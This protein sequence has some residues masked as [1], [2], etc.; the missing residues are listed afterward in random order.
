M[1]AVLKSTPPGRHSEQRDD[2][3]PVRPH[4]A[5]SGHARTGALQGPLCR[6]TTEGKHQTPTSPAQRTASTRVGGR[7]RLAA[8]VLAAAALAVISPVS[9]LARAHADTV[10][11]LVNVTVRPGYNFPNADAALA[12][13]HHICDELGAD[14][15][16]RQLVDDIERDFATTDEYQATY[17]LAQAADEL[18]PA[19]IWQLRRSAAEPVPTPAR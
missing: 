2:R 18:C 13:G 17:L 8:G 19:Q 11:Y 7:R 12:Y 10:A 1:T 16:Y 6:Y 5:A 15:S 4:R 14:V 9:P 3:R